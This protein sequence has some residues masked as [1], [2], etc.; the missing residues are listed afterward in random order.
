MV[1]GALAAAEVPMA[2][3][4]PA[5][6]KAG[7]VSWDIT[8][9]YEPAVTRWPAGEFRRAIYFILPKEP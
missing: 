6:A 9:R 3:D 7:I 5:T 4:V 8:C 1:L 2:V